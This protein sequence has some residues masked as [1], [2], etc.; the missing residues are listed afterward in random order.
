MELLGEVANGAALWDLYRSSHAFLHVSFTEGLPQVLFE[1]K[2]AGLPI[3]GTA[4]GGVPDALDGGRAGLLVRPDDA[5]AAVD[6]VDSL[7]NDP[8]LRRRLVEAGVANVRNETL[9]VQL[10]RIAAFFRT[11]LAAGTSGRRVGLARLSAESE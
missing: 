3:V 8:E 6:A 2:A 7:R 1:A 4:V 11:G 9:E 10:D 5:A